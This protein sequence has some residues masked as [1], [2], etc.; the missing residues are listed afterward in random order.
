MSKK[1]ITE[2]NLN[3]DIKYDAPLSYRHFRIFGWIMIVFAE[4]SIVLGITSKF[5]Y[6]AIG[7]ELTQTYQALSDVFGFFGQ[8]AIPFFLLANFAL[9]LSSQENIKQLV[10]TH[11]L[12]AVGIYLT[13]LLFYDRYFIGFLSL[14]FKSLTY[15]DTKVIVDAIMTTFFTGYLSLNV[16]IDLLMCSLLYLFLIYRPKNIK[17]NGLIFYRL[18][19]LIPIFYEIGS[20]V[21][22]GLSNGLHL[23]TIPIE[24]LPLLTN[25]SIITFFAFLIIILF[26]KNKTKIYKKMGGSPEQYKEYLQTKAH[27]F[28]VS[29]LIAIVFAICGLFDLLTTIIVPLIIIIAKVIKDEQDATTVSQVFN[30]IQPW[31]LGKAISLLFISP[32]ILL[33]N[34]KKKYSAKTKNIDTFIPIGGIAFCILALLEGLYLLATLS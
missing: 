7:P 3:N 14:L 1:A 30:M 33:F 12:G 8:L 22:K 2:F 9:I 21:I 28:Q 17:K 31:G 16:F 34:Y 20:F 19:V 27:T 24:V 5:F 32:F 18:L 13:F 4:L 29:V 26:L 25:K 15:E 6:N 11:V 10:L 23:F